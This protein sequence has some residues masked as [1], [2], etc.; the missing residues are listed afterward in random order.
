MVYISIFKHKGKVVCV[1]K[2]YAMKVYGAGS[3]S[4][5]VEWRCA[6]GLMLQPPNIWWRTGNP[7]VGPDVLAKIKIS[8]HHSYQ[9]SIY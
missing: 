9:Q 4:P 5:H 8:G 3:T 1:S 2:H 6:V 7:R